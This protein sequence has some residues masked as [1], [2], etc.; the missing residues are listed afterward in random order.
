M[1][2]LTLRIKIG[3]EDARLMEH[4]ERLEGMKIPGRSGSASMSQGERDLLIT[5]Y[6]RLEFITRP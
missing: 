3:A 1:S 2:P 5:A 6:E 4:I